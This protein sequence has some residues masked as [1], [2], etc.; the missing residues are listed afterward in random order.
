MK[1]DDCYRT[2]S[3]H[4]NEGDFKNEGIPKIKDEL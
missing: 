1:I 3:K 2:P 4:E